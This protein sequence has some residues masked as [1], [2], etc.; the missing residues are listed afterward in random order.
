MLY[1]H[2]RNIFIP[3]MLILYFFILKKSGVLHYYPDDTARNISTLLLMVSLPYG[4]L[5][6]IDK[7][8]GAVFFLVGYIKKK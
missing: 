3:I 6:V 5:F 4:I 7:L 8:Y 1:L 2:K